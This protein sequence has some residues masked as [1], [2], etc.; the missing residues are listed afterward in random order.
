MRRIDQLLSQYT[1]IHGGD[2]LMPREFAKTIVIKCHGLPLRGHGRKRGFFMKKAIIVLAAIAFLAAVLIAATATLHYRNMAAEAENT[3]AENEEIIWVEEE[4]SWED[5]GLRL[6]GVRFEEVV[7]TKPTLQGPL[8][9]EVGRDV[10]PRSDL[11]HILGQSIATR[12]EAAI[13]AKKV[14][15]SE[16]DNEDAHAFELMLV[17]YDPNKN[18]WIFVYWE[19]DIGLLGHDLNVAINGENGDYL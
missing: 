17:Q 12:D 6:I 3:E 15:K 2:I 4:D 9:D 7:L 8:W 18:I 19:N 5:D 10:E 16:Q 11:S 14:L 1:T 13:L